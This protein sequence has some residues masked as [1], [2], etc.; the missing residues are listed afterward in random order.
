MGGIV[1]KVEQ[2]FGSRRSS[3]RIIT[4][5]CTKNSSR[6][7]HVLP[8]RPNAKQR[9][10]LKVY[11]YYYYCQVLSEKMW[12]S[13]AFLFFNTRGIVQFIKVTRRF[14]ENLESIGVYIR[15]I[16]R[17]CWYGGAALRVQTSLYRFLTNTRWHITKVRTRAWTRFVLY[18][19]VVSTHSYVSRNISFV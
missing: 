8:L 18:R 13:F 6:I 9:Q 17:K 15:W 12:L 16:E 5:S 2:T 3:L 10:F 1:S 14:F 19:H 11:Y 4:G 7:G